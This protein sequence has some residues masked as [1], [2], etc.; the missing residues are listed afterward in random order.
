MIDEQSD[1]TA[2]FTEFLRRDG[3]NFDEFDAFLASWKRLVDQHENHSASP[4]EGIFDLSKIEGLAA[5]ALGR[6]IESDGVGST[7]GSALFDSLQVGAVICSRSGHIEQS[8]NQAVKSYG[9]HDGAELCEAGLVLENGD[10]FRSPDFRPSDKAASLNIF[11]CFDADGA[12][13]NLSIMPI[14]SGNS[15]HFLIVFMDTPW[16]PEAEGLLAAR[17]GLTEAEADIVG[18]FANGVSL[19]QIAADRGRAYQTIRNQF[20]AILEKTGCPNQADLLRLLLGTSYLFIQIESLAS[21]MTPAPGQVISM[22]RPGGRRLEVKMFGP[23]TGVPFICL[24]SIFGIPI[25]P[26]IE[27]KLSERNLLMLGIARPGF[28]NTSHPIKDQNTEECLAKDIAALLDSME[29]GSCAFVARASAA[30]SMFNLAR[31]MPERVSRALIV[32]SMVP[33]PYVEEQSVKSSWSK[34]LISA[35]RTSPTV[36]SLILGTGNRLRL[37][38]G[39]GRFFSRMYRRSDIDKNTALDPDVADSLSRGVA[40]VTQQGLTAGVKDMIEGFADWRDEVEAADLPITLFHGADDPHV[41]IGAVRSFA[42]DFADRVDLIEIP[43]GGGLLNY[44][45]IDQI[46]DFVSDGDVSTHP[47]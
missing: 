24:P 42:K 11:Q 36:T 33:R 5:N 14:Q 12:A 18:Q 37:Q 30:R 46:L 23:E 6:L 4:S 25:T 15:Q 26:A 47:E 27:T 35:S 13:I 31:I 21:V 20:R 32:N 3:F 19:K 45:H 28:G 22:P 41:P 7:A 34:S 1:E 16:G 2:V 9:L 29:I 17:F 8:N 44:T 43:N 39:S 38:M 40:C 10:P